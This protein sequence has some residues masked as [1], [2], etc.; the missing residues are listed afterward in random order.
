[1]MKDKTLL[2]NIQSAGVGGHILSVISEF[3]TDREQCVDVD[4]SFRGF[5]LARSSVLRG[6]VL[7][8]LLFIY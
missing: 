8:P 2:F 4:G 6:S 5:S 7:G 1:M 3:Y